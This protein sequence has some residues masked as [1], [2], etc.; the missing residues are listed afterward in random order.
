M[1]ETFLKCGKLQCKSN[2]NRNEVCLVIIEHIETNQIVPYLSGGY[3]MHLGTTWHV[4]CHV[5]SVTCHMSLYSLYQTVRARDLQFSH[6]FIIPY[7]SSVTCQV[8]HV[9]YHVSYV[10]HNV[11]HFLFCFLQSCWVGWLRLCYQKGLPRLVFR[12]FLIINALIP[13]IY[14]SQLA[15]V[16]FGSLKKQI[17]Q[18]LISERL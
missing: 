17:G 1:F 4:T 11:L 8:S 9:T 10:T 18:N 5:S 14:L 2:F 15:V 7:V 12:L 13:N 16:R 3:M 6:V